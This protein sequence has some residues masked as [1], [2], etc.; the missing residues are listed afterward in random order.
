MTHHRRSALYL[1]TFALWLMTVVL[2]VSSEYDGDVSMGEQTC[3]LL[4]L[5]FCVIGSV[6]SVVVSVLCPMAAAFTA[7]F[8]AAQRIADDEADEN[9][10]RR[11]HLRVIREQDA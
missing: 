5:T 8:K 4:S 2:L 11:P 6:S 3:L 9:A 7:G 10:E 1:T